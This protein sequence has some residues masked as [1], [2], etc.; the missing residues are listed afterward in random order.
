MIQYQATVNKDFSSSAQEPE[1]PIIGYQPR[2][3][4]K[5]QETT[6]S[7]EISEDTQVETPTETQENT[8][9]VETVSQEKPQGAEIDFSNTTNLGMRHAASKYLQQKL[10][11]TK[12][13][14][15]GLVGVWQ[16]ESGF[17]I[18]AENKEEKA[19]KNSSVKSNQYGIGIGQ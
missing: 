2:F 14:A 13:Q 19:G 18:N 16:A 10:G 11:L 3:R 5:T 9:Q 15:A 7:A 4:P 1:V 6:Q 12:E 17:N 8:P